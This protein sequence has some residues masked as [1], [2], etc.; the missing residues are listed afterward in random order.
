MGRSLTDYDEFAPT[1]A[2]ARQAVPWVVAPLARAVADLRPGATVLDVGCGTGNYVQALA[3]SRPDLL[4]VALDR[5]LPMLREAGRRRGA[6]RLVAADAAR[7]WPIP[8]RLGDL[9]LAVDVVHHLADLGCFFAEARRALRPGA[10]LLLA[11]DSEQ[12]LRQ[13]SLTRFFP[14]V[15]SIELGRYPKVTMVNRQAA[16]AGFM[17]EGEDSAEGWIPLTDEF[18]RSLEAKCSS[19]LRLLTPADHQAG[20]ARV[21]AAKARGERWHSC[22]VVLRYAAAAAGQ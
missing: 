15:L 17:K 4:Y 7:G 3:Q 18:V 10:R 6:A 20:M 5:S 2:W 16:E 14:E 19:A 21:R 8:D 22:Y 9:A 12:S 1:Y 13:R 11:T